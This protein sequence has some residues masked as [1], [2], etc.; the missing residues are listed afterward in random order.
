MALGHTTHTTDRGLGM[1]KKKV[2]NKAGTMRVPPK[3]KPKP[4]VMSKK[5]EEEKKRKLAVA[6][7]KRRAKNA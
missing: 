3:P 2:T 7:K 5:E 6:A 4:V 1:A